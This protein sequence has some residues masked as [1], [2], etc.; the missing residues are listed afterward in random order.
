ME[1]RLAHLEEAE[2]LATESCSACRI[3]NTLHIRCAIT[4]GTTQPR[5]CAQYKRRAEESCFSDR[6]ERVRGHG[7]DFTALRDAL[8]IL[9]P[10]RLLG[11]YPF[12]R[13]GT[14]LIAHG[15]VAQAPPGKVGEQ[16]SNRSI[17][18]FRGSGAPR[19]E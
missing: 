19:S 7:H 8:N 16:W 15:L 17:R 2:S 1:Y 3:G 18:L 5:T 12:I 9:R 11:M 10:S 13:A 4:V 6:L 14:S